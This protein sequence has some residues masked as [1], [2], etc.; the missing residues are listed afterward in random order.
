MGGVGAGD[1][2]ALAAL[3]ALLGPLH[4]LQVFIYTAL[5]G[6][7]MAVLHY[8]MSGRL[9]NRISTWKNVLLIF[10]STRDVQNLPQLNTTEKLRF[11]Y[12]AAF[13]FGFFAYTVWGGLINNL[14]H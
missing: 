8:A 11:P 1:V 7:G 9:M 10:I 2:K 14:S 3:G 5:I 12:A 13:A 6:G 4:V